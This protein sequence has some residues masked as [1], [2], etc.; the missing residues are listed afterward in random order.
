MS[1]AEKDLG[2]LMGNALGSFRLTG[3]T[4]QAAQ[5]PPTTPNG[6]VMLRR[7]WREVADM[8]GLVLSTRSKKRPPDAQ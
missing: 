5:I 3:H 6:P 7:C 2:S 4:I 8:F 1:S